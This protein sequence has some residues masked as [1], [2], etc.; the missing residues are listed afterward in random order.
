[1]RRLMVTAAG[2]VVA[3]ALAAGPA[4]GQ[5]T[6]TTVKPKTN[7]SSSHRHHVRWRD[8]AGV[9]RTQAAA[10]N[11]LSAM[12]AKNITTFQVLTL[13]RGKSKARFEVE[14]TFATHKAARTEARTVRQAGFKV[15]IVA[16]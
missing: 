3:L 4:F 8:V 6:T 13:H 11:R 2:A 12:Q 10:D 7:A 9:F 16:V 5:T 15:R 1:M 14:E